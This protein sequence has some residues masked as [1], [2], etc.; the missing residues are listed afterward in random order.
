LAHPLLGTGLGS[1][2]EA[3]QRAGFSLSRGG[4]RYPHNI[5]LQLLCETGLV[6]TG[7]VLASLV[8]WLRRLKV[9]SRWE[10]WGVGAGALAFLYFSLFDL[11]F[12][13]PELAWVFALMLGRLEFRTPKTVKLPKISASCVKIALLVVLGVTGFWPP[14]RPLNFAILATVLWMTAAFFQE[15]IEKVPGLFF[16]GGAFLLVRAFDSPSALGT[17][18]CLEMVGLALAFVLFLRGIADPGRFLKWFMG[19]GLF[20]G[21][22]VWAYSFRFSDIRDWTIF[23]NPKQ[24]GTFLVV[25]ALYW[26]GG[27]PGLRVG[28]WSK[29]V[30]TLFTAATLV[31]LKAF[32]AMAAAVAG[33]FSLLSTRAKWV[34]VAVGVLFLGIILYFRTWVFRGL[35]TSPTQWD[36]FGI[37]ASAWRVFARVPWFGAGPGAFAGLYHQVKAPRT[38]GVSRFLMDAQFAHNEFL[39]FL[40]AFGAV[41]VLFLLLFLVF[42][43]DRKAKGTSPSLWALGAAAFVD[44]CLHTPLILLQG[45]GLLA[46]DR[47]KKKEEGSWGSALLVG[48][49]A[50]GLFGSAAWAPRAMEQAKVLEAQGQLPQALRSLQYAEKVNA[51]DN[52]YTAA[53][54]EF[55]ESLFRATQDPA[56]A[57]AADEAFQ[58]SLSLE[59]TDGQGFLRDAERLTARL[60]QK[61][62]LEAVQSAEVAWAKTHRVLPFNA[63]ARFE[64]GLF[65]LKKGDREKA[66]LSFETAAQLEPNF[67]AAWMRSGWILKAKGERANARYCFRMALQAHERW[68]DAE[69]IDPLEKELIALPPEALEGLARETRP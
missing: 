65:Q 54:A 12:Q 13:M 36:R 14:F 37:W 63:F 19:L 25:G 9:P 67:A 10:G 44:F 62:T 58:R 60:D 45:A 64:E 22:A 20:F 23:P 52:R 11:P 38:N 39:E 34:G 8:G 30:A 18:R 55:L 66:L 57:S 43:W 3:Y 61:A 47:E 2:D 35:D 53:K 21:A 69:R 29:G 50:L 28:R 42:L 26:M 24:V 68:K 6:G 46:G 41:G 1:F 56:W 7:L 27:A 5:L 31:C 51:W 48:G 15:K 16:L 59:K 4:A 33:A 32:G 17:V 40:V 49:L